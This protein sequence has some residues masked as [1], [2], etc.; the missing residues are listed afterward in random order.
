MLHGDKVIESIE[1]QTNG[2]ATLRASVISTQPNG[3]Q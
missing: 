2:A 1:R 3:A